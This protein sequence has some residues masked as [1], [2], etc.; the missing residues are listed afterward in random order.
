MR[1]MKV[2]TVTLVS[3][4]WKKIPTL[5]LTQLPVAFKALFQITC[6]RFFCKIIEKHCLCPWRHFLLSRWSNK[7][8]ISEPVPLGRK[9]I[10]PHQS[11]EKSRAF[12][13]S[14]NRLPSPYP[15]P[16]LWLPMTI[17]L[18]VSLLLFCLSF[19]YVEI[20]NPDSAFHCWCHFC[21][22][23]FSMKTLYI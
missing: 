4:T 14:F 13:F 3:S 1:Q 21:F 23:D 15:C 18:W 7:L 12:L 17:T 9:L 11:V 6:V 5:F 19:I 8:L 2:L 20:M 16:S 22:S 10:N